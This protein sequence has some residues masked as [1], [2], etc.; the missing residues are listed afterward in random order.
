MGI[1]EAGIRGRPLE[2][3]VSPQPQRLHLVLIPSFARR[4]LKPGRG[5]RE[6][7]FVL[8]HVGIKASTGKGGISPRPSNAVLRKDLFLARDETK[9]K[10]QQC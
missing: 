10:W 8:S 2:K 7:E 9:T 1:S 3:C 6:I 5:A 4:R